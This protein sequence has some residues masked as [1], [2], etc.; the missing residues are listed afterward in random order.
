MVPANIQKEARLCGT[1]PCRTLVESE[2]SGR[3]RGRKRRIDLGSLLRFVQLLT[4]HAI[5]A[6]VPLR[7]LVTGVFGNHQLRAALDFH[8]IVGAE[9][10]HQ[11]HLAVLRRMLDF[12]GADG[13]QR[14][15]TEEFTVFLV[16]EL[17]HL[18]SDGLTFRRLGV[19]DDGLLGSHDPLAARVG[20]GAVQDR[21]SE[22]VHLLRE[23]LEEAGPD[24][25]IHRA[26]T[27]ILNQSEI[28]G[29]QLL[30]RGPVDVLLDELLLRR[31]LTI[32]RRHVRA[33]RHHVGAIRDL[34]ERHDFR[35]TFDGHRFGLT[36]RL[37]LHLLRGADDGAQ[38][39]DVVVI[40]RD[41]PHVRKRAEE[42]LGV[43]RTTAGATRQ[44]A[45]AVSADF[46][47]VDFGAC[48]F[49]HRHCDILQFGIADF[50]A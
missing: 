28:I 9:M 10:A 12:P 4:K 11:H 43:A 48:D 3:S 31:L 6:F 46:S 42:H 1:Q 37:V 35:V 14:H 47:V 24:L 41:D 34:C 18:A 5:E 50:R 15:A 19:V 23:W 7:R 40:I 44:E 38:G 36:G 25:D 13:P 17:R 49:D 27:E 8:E 30:E 16:D 45:E 21:T 22:L 39:D 20:D 29:A 32:L 33:D 2:R 26:V